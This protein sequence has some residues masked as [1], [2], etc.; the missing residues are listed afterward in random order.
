MQKVLSDLIRDLFNCLKHCKK[1]EESLGIELNNLTKEIENV[2]RNITKSYMKVYTFLEGSVS[3]IP[4][5]VV[6]KYPESL[7]YYF[8]IDIDS[9]NSKNEV[10]MDFRLIYLDQ[11]VKY[12]NHEFNIW[13]LKDTEF[14]K[15]CKELMEM[16]IPFRSDILYRLYNNS[17]ENGVGWKN[18]CVV[19]NGNECNII[20]NMIKKEWKLSELK[21]NNEK[22]RIECIIDS[23]YELIIQSFSTFLNNHSNADEL[24]S[25]ID[26]KLLN[27]FIDEYSLDMNNKDVQSF[28]YPIYSPL[29]KESIINTEQYDS[30]L[31]EWIGDFK[32]KLIYRA[33]EH[34][35]TASSFHEYCD[36]IDKP[37]LILIKDSKGDIFGG[38]TTQ[39][40][41]GNGMYYSLLSLS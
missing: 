32:W 19:V 40:W 8:M 1:H 2:Y 39:S 10:E 29:L 37:N 5:N 9:R 28:F 23:K 14:D 21:Y 41:G 3:E 7:I 11:I 30:Y 38:F 4:N 16:R 18:R 33:S 34:D 12:M 17:N 22:S 25:V 15:F 24:Y 13:K 27:T 6:M 26:R 20:A 35:Y 36:K 31:K